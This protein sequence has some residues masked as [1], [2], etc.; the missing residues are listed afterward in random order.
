M[1]AKKVLHR[2]LK[3]DNIMLVKDAEH[4]A[5]HPQ[6]KLI[7]FGA[8]KWCKDEEFLGKKFIGTVQTIAP[9]VIVA[10]GDEFDAGDESQIETTHEVVYKKRPFGIRKYSP[11]S[12]GAGAKVKILGDKPRY[13]GDPI[14]QA[15]AAGVQVEWAVQSVNGQDVT[16]MMMDDIVDTMGDRLLDNSS[17]GAFDGSFKVTGDNKGKGK[18]VPTIEPVELPCTVVYAQMKPKPYGPKVD[19]WSLGCILY[20]MKTGKTPFEPE[21]ASVT[22]GVYKEPEGVSPE[23]VDIV[24]KMLVVDPE[25]RAT[26]EEVCSHPWL[27]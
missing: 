7:D 19:V 13:P 8:S 25:K 21:E 18:V 10:R 11:G 3:T 16:K 17:R 15:F 27:Q 22:A 4:D 14:G 9:E 6:V 5:D 20:S 2:D 1:H 12:N 23:F 24:S 26:L